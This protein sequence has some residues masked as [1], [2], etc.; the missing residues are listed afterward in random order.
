VDE[1]IADR[2]KGKKDY[3]QLLLKPASEVKG[4]NLSAGFTG[5]QIKHRIVMITKQRSLPR[6]KLMFTILLPLTIL[7]MLSFSYIKNPIPIPTQEQQNENAIYAQLKIGEITWKGNT[8]Y[9]IKTLNLAFGLKTGDRYNHEDINTRLWLSDLSSLYQDNGYLFSKI[10]IVE[11][12]N[13]EVVDLTI[14]IYEGKQV[15]VHDIIVKINGIVTKDIVNQIGIH[16]GE[17]F[18]RAKILKSTRALAAMGK[19][20]PEKIN[21]KPIAHITTDEFDSVDLLYELTEVINKK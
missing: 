2:G 10:S 16:P 6:F 15:K 7:L 13:N 5:N 21:P 17:L 14:T 4:F 18:S 12:Q 20:D 19:F 8:V 11:N 3:A 1:K 9:D